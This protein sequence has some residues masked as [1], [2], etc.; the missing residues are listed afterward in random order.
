MKTIFPFSSTEISQ[1]DQAGS[2]ALT[3]ITMMREG[4]PVPPGFVL[5]VNF[6][7]PWITT[8]QSTP[9]WEAVQYSR[10]EDIGQIIKAL[11]SL[12]ADLR[13]NHQ[14]Q[15]ELD[16]ALRSFQESY[17]VDFFAVRSSSPEED[18]EGASFAGATKQHW[19]SRLKK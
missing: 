9:E 18:L 13:F 3:L 15:E 7:E 12:C 10:V 2:K 17:H 1:L 4:T 16:G 19:V 8:L 6:F 14:Q 5:T 11:Q